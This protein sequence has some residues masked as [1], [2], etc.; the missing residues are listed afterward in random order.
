[1][2]QIKN[3]LVLF[4]RLI[5]ASIAMSIAYI[6][7]TFFI[8]QTELTM[9]PE[10]ASWAGIA[11]FLVSTINALV[12][13]YPT[14]RSRWHGLK[15]IGVVF[16]VQFGVETFLTQIE[17]LY[18]NRTLQISTSEMTGIVSAGAI[19]ALI[20]APLAVWF[21]GRMKG[22]GKPEEKMPALRV[23]AWIWRFT[24]LTVLYP[25]IYFLFGYYVAWQW[26]ETRLL[27]SGTRDI[28]PLVTYFRGV[29]ASDPYFIP[30]QLMRG[31]MWTAIA[32]LIV[33][34]MNTRRWE[35]ALAVALVFAGLDCSP[36]HTCR[37]WCA[38]PT[39]TSS[40]HPCCCSAESQAGF[41]PTRNNRA[42]NSRSSMQ[43]KNRMSASRRDDH[44]ASLKVP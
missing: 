17:S 35:S 43:H 15:L 3:S 11:L 14:L 23:S 37:P 39:S 41:Y 27:Y 5:L 24:G 34:M 22:S 26:E 31:A 21:L 4:V 33:N 10:E 44:R 13:S 9:T 12:L 6:V 16:L 29:F 2:S 8:S 20:F 25:I 42:N 30:F 28:L 40:F 19:R 1:M 7:S 38:N 18:F 32:I 36:I